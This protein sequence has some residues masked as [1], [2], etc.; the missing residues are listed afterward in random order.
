MDVVVTESNAKGQQHPAASAEP[1]AEG[2]TTATAPTMTDAIDEPPE[3]EDDESGNFGEDSGG[4]FCCC[5]SIASTT[6]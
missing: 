5:T 1:T 2:L 6:D 4:G 3:E